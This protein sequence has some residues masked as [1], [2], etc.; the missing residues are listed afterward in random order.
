MDR[1]AV[2]DKVSRHL[3]TQ[4]EKS[5][6]DKG[7]DQT[8]MCL[9]RNRKGRKCAIGGL[10]LDEHYKPSFEGHGVG[11]PEVM[12]AVELSLGCTITEQRDEEFLRDLQSI[13]DMYE[14]S[15]WRKSLGYFAATRG[16]IF[17]PPKEMTN[18]A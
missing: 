17:N 1:Q 14:P 3:L 5:L 8:P 7:W 12:R 9:Y 11:F 13:H 18:A 6:D 4:N 15:R 2:L 10:I 16:L